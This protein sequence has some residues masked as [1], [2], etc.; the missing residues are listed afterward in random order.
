[1]SRSEAASVGG[2]FELADDSRCDLKA[3]PAQYVSAR[4]N[5]SL[6]PRYGHPH[7]PGSFGWQNIA[8]ILSAM[9]GVWL[10]PERSFATVTRMLLYGQSSLSMGTTLS[11]GAATAW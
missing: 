5:H 9:T 2:L 4:T 7:P 8:L 11:F 10:V 1:M 6:K 3:R